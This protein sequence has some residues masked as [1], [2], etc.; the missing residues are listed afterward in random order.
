MPDES[1]RK[2]GGIL[3]ELKKCHECR[4]I[5]CWICAECSQKTNEQFHFDCINDLP[6]ISKFTLN[7]DNIRFGL[8]AI[9]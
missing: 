4:Q 1:C 5:Y 2:C 9:T 6:N 8:A 7:T 3:I